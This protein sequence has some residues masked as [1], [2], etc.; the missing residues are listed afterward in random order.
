LPAAQL[1]AHR[2]LVRAALD[3]SDGLYAGTRALCD[4]NGLGAVMAPEMALDPVLERICGQAEVSTFQLG[5]TWGDWC[6]LV[7]VRPGDVAPTRSALSKARI[8]FRE[9]GRLTAEPGVRVDDGSPQP[10]VWHGTDQ[11]R[12]SRSSWHGT[13]IDEQIRRMRESRP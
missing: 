13:G 9:V 6:L 12:F 4:A 11:E 2:G 7:A 8:G 1:L 5:A 3:L 10:P